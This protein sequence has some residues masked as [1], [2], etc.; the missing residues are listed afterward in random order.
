MKAFKILLFV[1]ISSMAF[2]AKCPTKLVLDCKDKGVYAFESEVQSHVIYTNP[3]TTL[4]FYD[5]SYNDIKAKFSMDSRIRCEGAEVRITAT[6]SNILTGQQLKTIIYSFNHGN[7]PNMIVMQQAPE[8]K[9]LI[10]TSCRIK[11]KIK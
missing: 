4:N 3:E 7:Y 10:Q 9:T 11:E 8:V 2:A 6:V 1:S 5:G